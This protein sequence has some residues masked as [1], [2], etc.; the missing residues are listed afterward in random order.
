LGSEERNEVENY[1]AHELS[2][3]LGLCLGGAWLIVV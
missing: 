1:Y 2:R 3:M